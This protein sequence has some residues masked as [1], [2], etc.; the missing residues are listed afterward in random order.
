VMTAVCRSIHCLAHGEDGIQLQQQDTEAAA[1]PCDDSTVGD[2]TVAGLTDGNA[3]M[4]LYAYLI[5]C[6]G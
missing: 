5:S 6:S 1:G 3:E 4:V 2:N